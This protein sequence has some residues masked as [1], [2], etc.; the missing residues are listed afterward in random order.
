LFC[1][2]VR[3][4]TS[5]LQWNYLFNK[6]VR[7]AELLV[8]KKVRT[9]LPVQVKHSIQKIFFFFWN[10]LLT[11]WLQIKI[12]CLLE[13]KISCWILEYLVSWLWINNFPH[14][15]CQISN[16]SNLLRLNSLYVKHLCPFS[17]SKFNF[18]APASPVYRARY[19]TNWDRKGWPDSEI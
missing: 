3:S 13:I 5:F 1:K 4:V 12:V 15:K 10:R 11:V 17:K 16:A 6:F 9:A 7:S 2:I 19:S 14:L 8:Q 18:L